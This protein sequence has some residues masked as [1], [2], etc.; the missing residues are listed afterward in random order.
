MIGCMD[1]STHKEKLL[2]ALHQ[3]YT[4]LPK[5]YALSK[6]PKMFREWKSTAHCSLMAKDFVTLKQLNP[7]I[8]RDE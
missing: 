2:K 6:W 5:Q 3:S 8:D 7:A 4:F 1:I